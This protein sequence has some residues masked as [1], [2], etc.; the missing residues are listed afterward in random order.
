[1]KKTI[2]NI[3]T[4]LII[5]TACQ[6]EPINSP[7][8]DIENLIIKET[9][10]YIIVQINGIQEKLEKKDGKY[11]YYDDVCYTKELLEE[12]IKFNNNSLKKLQVQVLPQENGL[13]V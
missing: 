13:V 3:L 11:F 10:E 6:E 12:L 8:Q 1:M 7:K 4:L 5:L 2:I 9:N